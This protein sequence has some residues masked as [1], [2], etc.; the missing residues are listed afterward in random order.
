MCISGPIQAVEGEADGKTWI[1]FGNLSL[2][3]SCFPGYYAT[4][5]T[6]TMRLA[7]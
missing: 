4:K 1:I 2:H 6:E 7:S 5:A 3:V